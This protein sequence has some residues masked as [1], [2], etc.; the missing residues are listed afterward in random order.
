[1]IA[2]FLSFFSLSCNY[3]HRKVIHQGEKFVK[4]ALMKNFL[5]LFGFV[6]LMGCAAFFEGDEGVPLA[7]QRITPLQL[8]EL[9]IPFTHR[10]NSDKSFHLPGSAAIDIDEDGRFEVF[11]GGGLGQNDVLLG[12]KNGKVVNKIKG[13]GLSSKDA[14]Y[15]ATAI[16]LDNNG[17]VDLIAMRDKSATIYYKTARGKFEAVKLPLKLQKHSVAL[18]ATPIDIEQDG[19]IDLYISVFIDSEH[20]RSVTYNDPSHRRYNILLRNDGNRRWT[21]ITEET[22]RGLQNSFTAVSVDLNKDNRQDLVLSQNTGEV[23]ILHNLGKG[24]F[25]KVPLDTGFGFW[26][27]AAMGDVDN[28]GDIDMLFSNSGSSITGKILMGDL[29]ENMRFNGSWIMLRNE[30]NFRFTNIS[31][32]ARIA[33]L[34]FGWGAVFEDMNF[35]GAVDMFGA[36]NYIKWLPHKLYKIDGKIM[37]NDPQALA[38]FYLNRGDSGKN[39][40]FANTPLLVDFDGDGKKDLFWINS[41]GPTK[42]FLNNTTG[43]HFLAVGL[44][45]NV[46]TL[47]AV[48]EITYQNKTYRQQMTSSQGLTTDQPP[49]VV[50]GLGKNTK[51]NRL[52]IR[53]SNGKITTRS[54]PPIDRVLKISP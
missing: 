30:G 17:K 27:G 26:M 49:V 14:T 43:N 2:I 33:D 19:D 40:Y 3:K 32:K 5:S 46:L 36:Q 10:W 44:P 50:F 37:L 13:T 21:D 11:I 18:N 51:V 48:V 42:A 41:N 12:Y 9:T 4:V 54:N 7:P 47:G 34:G 25:A 35:D 8:Q 23:E 22:T 31:K 38:E 53:W 16:D 39:P 15:G 45:D 52:K 29:K 28:D 6:L 1:M 20:F 24:K